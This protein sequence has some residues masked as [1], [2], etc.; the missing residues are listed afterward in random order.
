MRMAKGKPSVTSLVYIMENGNPIF[1]SLD[2]YDLHRLVLVKT[3][4]YN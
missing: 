3:T 2:W 1:W 4:M